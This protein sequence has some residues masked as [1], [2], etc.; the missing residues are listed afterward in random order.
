MLFFLVTSDM[1]NGEEASKEEV[2]A[3][4]RLAFGESG[5]IT[6]LAATVSAHCLN[7]H[8]LI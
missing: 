4:K 5:I 1:D 3:G 8:K 6:L 2:F 7:L